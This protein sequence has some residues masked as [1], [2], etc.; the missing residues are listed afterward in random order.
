MLIKGRDAATSH[1]GIQSATV[2]CL[3]GAGITCL[4]PDSISRFAVIL[5]MAVSALVAAR[6]YAVLRRISPAGESCLA[7][8]WLLLAPAALVLS[9]IYASA[10]ALDAGSAR[11]V[12]T[13]AVPALTFLGVALSLQSRNRQKVT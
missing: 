2:V 13:L 10:P 6:L 5:L 1:R 4:L 9:S 7:V 11:I 3:V 8:A 12:S